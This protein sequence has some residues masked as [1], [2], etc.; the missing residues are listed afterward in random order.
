MVAEKAEEESGRTKETALLLFPPIDATNTYV[1]R[2][3]LIHPL[4][5]PFQ[6]ELP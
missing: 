1:S 6:E 4:F 5:S 2:G 3:V